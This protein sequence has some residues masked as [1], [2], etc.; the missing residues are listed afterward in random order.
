MVEVLTGIQNGGAQVSIID[1]A[2]SRNF[3]CVNNTG[4]RDYLIKILPKKYCTRKQTK[5][6]QV[7]EIVES[8]KDIDRDSLQEG[9]LSSSDATSECGSLYQ[10][11]EK[12]QIRVNPSRNLTAADFMKVKQKGKTNTKKG[13]RVKRS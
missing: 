11:V 3:S 6:D 7:R 10:T 4:G 13:A 9:V 8:S 12:K 5:D 2:F 1:D